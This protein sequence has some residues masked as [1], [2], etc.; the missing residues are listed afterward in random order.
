MHNMLNYIVS[1]LQTLP[2]SLITVIVAALP[3]SELRGAIPLALLTLKQPVLRT[4]CLAI[5]GNLLPVVP[6][7]FGLE[8]VSRYLRRFRLWHRFFEWLFA[9]TERKAKIVARFEVIGLALFVAIPLPVTG[10]WT[11]CVAA[12]LFKIKFRYAFAAIILGVIIAAV[13]VTILTLVG[14]EIICG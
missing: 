13:I 3:V 2:K 6:L 4:F 10:A 11:G 8:P 14:K 1:N 5:L 7:L 9:R 12:T